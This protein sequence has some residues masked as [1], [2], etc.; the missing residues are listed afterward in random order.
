MGEGV[1]GIYKARKQRT[2]GPR[3]IRLVLLHS[4]SK[5]ALYV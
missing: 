3:G 5:A 2:S 4:G 1:K